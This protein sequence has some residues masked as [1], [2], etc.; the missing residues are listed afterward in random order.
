[1]KCGIEVVIKVRNV[2]DAKR[3]RN[4]WN[5]KVRLRSLVENCEK[6]KYKYKSSTVFFF[7]VFSSSHLSGHEAVHARARGNGG[8][9]AGRR[10]AAAAAGAG[11]HHY[12]NDDGTIY[13]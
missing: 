11:N 7:T 5:Q 13:F 3:P 4:V 8:G 1:M 12:D 10:A 6:R 9:S 2:P